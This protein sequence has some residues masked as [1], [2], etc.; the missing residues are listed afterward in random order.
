MTGWQFFSEPDRYCALCG[1]LRCSVTERL[2]P[3]APAFMRGVTA[4]F[5]SD[6]HA[7][8]TTTDAAMTALK[9]KA[10]ALRPDLLLL[11][12]DYSDR[13][14]PTERLFERLAAIPAPLGRFAVVG[15]NDREAFP[16]ID[17]LRRITARAGF[18]LLINES[19]TLR[20]DGGTLIVAGL[21]EY[22]YGAPDAAG[23]YPDAPAPD[24]CRLLLSHYPCGVRP[25][26]DLMLCGHTHVPCCHRHEGFTY[27][28]PGSV[29]LPKQ[30]T[31]HSYVTLED[32]VM[33]W[34]DLVGGEF[35]RERVW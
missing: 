22:R 3:R 32:G 4:L 19:R 8:P 16:D 21:D 33:V 25:M 23:L 10:A 6:V 20:L 29:S 7:L 17:N 14:G 5:I 31:P 1:D 9:A 27:V 2:I 26:P 12:G 34:K 15:N 11:G 35:M 30:N 24:R 18:E 13:P 28:N